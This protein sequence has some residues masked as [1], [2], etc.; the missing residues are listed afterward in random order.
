ME[1]EVSKG[2]GEGCS[3]LGEFEKDEQEEREKGKNLQSL[4]K[5]L[6]VE[7]IKETQQRKRVQKTKEENKRKKSCEGRGQKRKTK[8]GEM[9][10]K[11]KDLKRI[12]PFGKAHGCRPGILIN[13]KIAT[14]THAVPQHRFNAL[15]GISI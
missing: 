4:K 9:E 13:L 3:T 1:Q 11:N 2:D 15:Y 8:R 5:R 10:G 7:G 12:R 14:R 6:K